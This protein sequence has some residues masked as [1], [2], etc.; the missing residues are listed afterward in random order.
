MSVINLALSIEAPDLDEASSWSAFESLAVQMSKDV[1]GQALAQALDELQEKLIEQVCGPKWAP[2]RGL[3]APFACPEC[4]TASDFARKGRRTRPRRFDTAAGRV[5][6][7][8]WHVGCR[9]CGK[10]FAPL[11]VML[12]LQ[13]KRRTDRLSLDLAELASQMSFRRSATVAETFSGRRASGGGA[14]RA[15]ADIAAIVAPDGI[16]GPAVAQADVVILDG[17]GVRAGTRRL[18]ADCNVAIGLTGR[19]GPKSRRRAHAQLLGLT[20]GESWSTLGDQLAAMEPPQV[21]IVDGELAVTKL[22]TDIWPNVP[23]QRCWWHLCRAFRWALYADKAPSSWANERRAELRALLQAAIANE[24]STDDALCLYDDFVEAID[25]AGHH[26]AT[27]LLTVARPQVFTCL[28][29]KLR[30]HLA[31]LGGPELGSG[32]IERTMRDI[33][34]RVDIGGSRW[35]IPGIRDTI[36]VLAARR[37]HHPA[38]HALTTNLRPPNTIP[39]HLAKFNAG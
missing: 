30:R 27:S 4:A 33:N 3:P 15:M 6:V 24:R 25:R 35:T 19:S 22:A 26:A 5:E 20:V 17:T 23:Q 1:P 7:R 2:Q 11:L 29:P 38:W 37:F 8:L 34:A 12:D 16:I 9:E 36:N 28:D 21:V 31:H 10:V 39:F 14:H 32:V 18:G 13:G